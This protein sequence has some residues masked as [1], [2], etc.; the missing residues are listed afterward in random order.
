MKITVSN[1]N[2]TTVKDVNVNSNNRHDQVHGNKN[3][4][5]GSGTQWNVRDYIVTKYS[6]VMVSAL[7]ALAIAW[8]PLNLSMGISNVF[9]SLLTS[10]KSFRLK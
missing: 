5:N 9:K 6:F 7:A 10:I 8:K 4:N 2:D 3:E 1:S